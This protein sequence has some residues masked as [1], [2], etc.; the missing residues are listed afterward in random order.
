MKYDGVRG[1]FLPVLLLKH[2]EGQSVPGEGVEHPQPQCSSGFGASLAWQAGLADV[3]F[4]RA[5]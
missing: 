3:A 5:E 2:L 1:L 4:S